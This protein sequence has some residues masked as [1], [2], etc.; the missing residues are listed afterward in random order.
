[1]NITTVTGRPPKFAVT[2]VVEDEIKKYVQIQFEKR[3][4][5]GKNEKE[6]AELAL[7]AM[8]YLVGEINDGYSEE[9]SVADYIKEEN[10]WLERQVKAA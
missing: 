9:Y 8:R 10:E 6:S 2:K 1:M 3:L 5:E 7:L 4:S